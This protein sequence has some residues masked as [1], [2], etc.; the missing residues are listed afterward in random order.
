[1][2]GQRVLATACADYDEH[3]VVALATSLRR[4]H[5]ADLVAAALTQ[6]E[7]RRRARAKFGADAD[8]MYFTPDGLEQAT[9]AS[10]AAHRARRFAGLGP[11][12]VVDLGCGI[13]GD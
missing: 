2:A 10:V 8:S 12:S 7:L 9:R 4:N 6:A 13:G 1:P 3:R 5:P 11:A